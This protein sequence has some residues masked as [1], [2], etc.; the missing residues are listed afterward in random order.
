MVLMSA[1]NQSLVSTAHIKAVAMAVGTSTF[2]ES[3]AAAVLHLLMTP[4]VAFAAP[5]MFEHKAD[6]AHVNCQIP[7]R[8]KL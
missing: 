3:L 5:F 2:C 7:Y 4:L 8:S 1:C 6:P